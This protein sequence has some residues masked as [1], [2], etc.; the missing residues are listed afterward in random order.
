MH[1]FASRLVVLLA[2]VGLAATTSAAEEIVSPTPVGLFPSCSAQPAAITLS[3]LDPL[4]PGQKSDFLIVG[5]DPGETVR[6]AATAAGT[7][8]GPCPPPLGGLCVD[9]LPPIR[10]LGSATADG[11]GNA[12]LQ[13]AVPPEA[14]PISVSAQAVIQRGPGGVDSVKSNALTVPIV[15]FNEIAVLAPVVLAPGD[16]PSIV[17]DR[18]CRYLIGTA[19]GAGCPFSAD[20][21]VCVECDQD[22]TKCPASISYKLYDVQCQ[23][24]LCEGRWSRV[25]SA[26]GACDVGEK[27]GYKFK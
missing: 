19:T 7:G 5:A 18:V 13:F 25:A 14:P 4:R 6:Y 16:L 8:R 12:V 2:L 17:E 24:V 9:L 1:R 21:T 10:S 11:L 3:V 22:R 15:D 26:C 23:Q 27:S 20:D